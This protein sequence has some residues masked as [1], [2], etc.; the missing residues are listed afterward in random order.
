MENDS[1]EKN[2]KQDMPDENDSISEKHNS[3]ETEITEPKKKRNTLAMVL[4]FLMVVFAGVAIFFGVEYFKPKE[5]KCEQSCETNNVVSEN[6]EKTEEK[7]T[8]SQSMAEQYKE[9]Y[10][11]VKKQRWI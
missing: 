9:V 10:D 5:D 6:N 3:L 2:K 1:V 8:N 11:V 7:T 4:G